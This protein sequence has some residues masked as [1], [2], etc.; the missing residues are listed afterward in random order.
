MAETGTTGEE[1]QG[2]TFREVELKPHQIAILQWS[3]H[4]KRNEEI[5]LL[6]NLARPQTVQAHVMRIM[7]ATGTSSRT[8]AVAWALRRGLIK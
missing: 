1:G 4:G 2:F 8:A 5:A 6:M 7:E 3:A